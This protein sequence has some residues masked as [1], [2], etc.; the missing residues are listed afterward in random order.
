MTLNLLTCPVQCLC[1]FV[2]PGLLPLQSSLDPSG[3]RQ[4]REECSWHPSYFYGFPS[5]IVLALSKMR[6]TLIASSSSRSR[7]VNHS[8]KAFSRG[9]LGTMKM[10][11][12]GE[13]RHQWP[14]ALQVISGPLTMQ[15]NCGYSCTS[16][17]NLRIRTRSSQAID[18]S[19]SKRARY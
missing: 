2:N 10:I 16:V 6:I 7:S 5:A 3:V 18:H 4:P 9:G 1:I 12:A 17:S 13:I 11:P 8:V 14:I 15:M 19:T